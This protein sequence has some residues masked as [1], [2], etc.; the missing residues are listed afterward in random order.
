MAD[1]KKNT[2]DEGKW[3]VVHTYSGYENKVKDKIEMLIENK[4]DD[5]VFDVRVPLEKYTE[6]KNH[7]RVIKERKMLPGYVLVKMNITPTSWYLIRNTQGVTGF[8][9]PGSDPVPLTA[10]EIAQFGVREQIPTRDIDVRPGDTVEIIFGPFA[11][12]AAE[13]EEVNTEK[14]MIKG[15]INMFGRETSV[16]MSFDDI[17]TN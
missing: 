2:P 6:L 12:F 11:G 3:Y 8:V 10:R 4:Q 9:G 16:E 17:E 7:Q 1:L 15:L 14:Q 13:V 5:N